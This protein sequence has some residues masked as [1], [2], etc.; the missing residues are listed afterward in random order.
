MTSNV[1][2]SEKCLCASQR[3][4]VVAPPVVT[5]VQEAT[6][7]GMMQTMMNRLA[8]AIVT[9]LLIAPLVMF[10]A[11]GK[12][13]PVVGPTA[14][15][16]LAADQELARALEA[17]DTVGIYRMLDKDWAVIPSNGNV[18]EGPSV[19]PSGI[20]TGARTLK[21]MALSEPRVRLYGNIALVTTKVEL[22]AVSI[23]H[24]GDAPATW[25]GQLRQTD[26]WRW[27]SGGWKC[28]LTQEAK[29][30]G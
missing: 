17:N 18:Y 1:L 21:K 16:A 4:N 27:K 19:F 10:G 24:N 30:S 22:V 9:G 7:Q 25:S 3:N 23:H 14:E 8:I 5:R 2:E 13:K 26:V 11:A 15:N 28:I 29:I 6:K 12:M 20:R